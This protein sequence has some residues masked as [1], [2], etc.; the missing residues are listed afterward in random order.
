[1]LIT[2]GKISQ[3]EVLNYYIAVVLSAIFSSSYPLGKH[4][5]SGQ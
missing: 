3:A 1:M 4:D 2:A 5:V